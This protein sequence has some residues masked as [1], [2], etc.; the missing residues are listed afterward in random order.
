MRILLFIGIIV[1]LNSCGYTPIYSSKDSNF[2]VISLK[3]NIN[4]SSTN[5]IQNSIR[6]FSNEDSDKNLN[7]SF[8]FKEDITVILKDSKGNPSR[9]RLTIKVDLSVLDENQNL[10][11]SKI[12]SEN[13]EYN[14]DDNKFNLKQYEKNIKLNLVEQITEQILAFLANVK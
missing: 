2:K 9:N 8:N 12:F 1:L 7:I 10:I 4:N 11:T 13:F 14:I 6:V 3:K 5:Y